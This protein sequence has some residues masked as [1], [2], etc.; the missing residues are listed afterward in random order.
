MS[1]SRALIWMQTPVQGTCS[2]WAGPSRC[3]RAPSPKHQ[4]SGELATSAADHRAVL[5]PSR[6]GAGLASLRQEV[7]QAGKVAVMHVVCLLVAGCASTPPP[8]PVEVRVPVPV[9]CVSAIPARPALAWDDLVDARVY[10]QVRALLIDRGR[11][12]AHVD[13]LRAVLGVCASPAEDPRTTPQRP[14]A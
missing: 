14:G 6:R 11:L 9:P 3:G 1:E 10:E 7:P 13:E 12:V 2:V 8:L 4:A 5:H